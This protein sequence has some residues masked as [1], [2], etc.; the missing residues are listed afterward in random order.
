MKSIINALNSIAESINNLA[1]S[2]KENRSS[3]PVSIVPQT[4]TSNPTS[5][6]SNLRYYPS[7]YS[8]ESKSTSKT[9]VVSIE[10]YNAIKAIY[11]ALTD[12]GS[13]PVHHDSVSKEIHFKWP[14]LGKALNQLVNAYAKNH[15]KQNKYDSMHKTYKD[16]WKDK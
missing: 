6:V 16:I 14:V 4:I 15:F 7:P 5:S 13:H 2:I 12:K 1:N 8:K 11:N 10:E 3:S 9:I